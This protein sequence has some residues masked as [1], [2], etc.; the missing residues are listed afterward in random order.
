MNPPYEANVSPF[1]K[2]A[3]LDACAS[4]VGGSVRQMGSLRLLQRRLGPWTGA[5]LPLPK[6]ATPLSAGL[7]N[8][9]D[10]ND[11]DLRGIDEWFW[12]SGL[13]FLQ[14]TS[15][16]SPPADL[17]A[18]RIEPFR[19]LEIDLSPTC[20]FLWSASSQL[21]RRAVRKS[22]KARVRVH[23]AI[24]D[25]V[26]LAEHRRIARSVY[27]ASGQLPAHTKFHHDAV[28]GSS[29]REHAQFF[30]A[31]LNGTNLGH[32]I[33][34]RHLDRA[35]YWD[36][37]VNQ[38]GRNVGA[39]HLLFWA[40]MRWCKRHGVTRLDLMGPPEGGRAGTAAGIGRFKLSFGAKPQDYWVVYWFRR[41]AGL[42]LDVSRVLSRLRQANFSK[43]VSVTGKPTAGKSSDTT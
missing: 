41:G 11:R 39:G 14:V 19:N 18:S 35:Y 37:A 27:E 36:V 28:M 17:R 26:K 34:I 8:D 13:S 7:M 12:K 32:L 24:P 1:Q 22:L 15:S 16:T 29:L 4:S 42:G 6:S 33:S 21:P 9:A 25:E 38:T 2:L 3:W 20:D 30:S 10:C 43:L 23:V 31:S 5:G 40:W